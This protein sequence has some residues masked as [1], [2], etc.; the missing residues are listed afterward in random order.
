MEP[1]DGGQ[2]LLNQ[3]WGILASEHTTA[4]G[5]LSLEDFLVRTSWGSHLTIVHACVTVCARMCVHVRVCECVHVLGSLAHCLREVGFSA[6]EEEMGGPGHCC[7]FF[8]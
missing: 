3:I 2:P 6:A 4:P 5:G 8:F 1:C 7:L